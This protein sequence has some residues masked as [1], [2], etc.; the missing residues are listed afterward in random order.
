MR[1]VACTNVECANHG[2]SYHDDE[3]DETIVLCP[4][5]EKTMPPTTLEA[6]AQVHAEKFAARDAA[7]AKATAAVEAEAVANPPAAPVDPL[8]ALKALPPDR[9]VTASDLLAILSPEDL[10]AHTADLGLQKE[11]PDA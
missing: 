8:A 9:V 11:S 3:P 6:L 1:Y 2:A 5:C 10:D 4:L 7:E